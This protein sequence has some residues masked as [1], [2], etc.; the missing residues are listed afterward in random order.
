MSEEPNPNSLN[1]Q[2]AAEIIRGLD[3]FGLTIRPKGLNLGI[4]E[5]IYWPVSHI[6]RSVCRDFHFGELVE[7]GF[8]VG[9]YVLTPS[10]LLSDKIKDAIRAVAL[11]HGKP[12][13]TKVLFFSRPDC[14]AVT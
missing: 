12:F 3:N 4:P 7:T 9:I 1:E 13:K 5:K 11:E 8:P 2:V 6:L 14:G 10:L